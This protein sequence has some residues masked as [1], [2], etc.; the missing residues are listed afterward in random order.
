MRPKPAADPSLS[1]IDS[2]IR[3][4]SAFLS[5]HYA[6][7]LT[8]RNLPV[9]AWV[10]L[11]ELSHGDIDA[12][13]TLAACDAAT[14]PSAV[15]TELAAQIITLMETQ[16]L[17]LPWIQNRILIPLELH[18]ADTPGIPCPHRADEMIQ[19]LKGAKADQVRLR[20]PHTV[21]EQRRPICRPH[22]ERF[23]ERFWEL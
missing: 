15:I 3:E 10:W 12:I 20:R 8:A 16:R 22:Q 5:G 9:P 19:I 17:T 4:S 6:K 18:L 21:P 7:C 23:K 13:R 2:L 14:G 11:N 1:A